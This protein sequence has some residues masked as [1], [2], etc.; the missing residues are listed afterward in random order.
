MSPSSTA[1]TDLGTFF[2]HCTYCTVEGTIESGVTTIQ[3]L[4]SQNVPSFGPD[5]GTKAV[6]DSTGAAVAQ[7]EVNI[8]EA[9][10]EDYDD[11]LE[12]LGFS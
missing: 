11:L 5:G 10:R 9:V 12:E 2:L 6:L 7:L 3:V 8:A 1:T 4:L